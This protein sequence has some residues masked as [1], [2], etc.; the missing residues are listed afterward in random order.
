MER[1]LLAGMFKDPCLLHGQRYLKN[2]LI[3][4]AICDLESPLPWNT[5]AVLLEV[6]GERGVF[7][8]ASYTWGKCYF[9]YWETTEATVSWRRLLVNSETSDMEIQS[10]GGCKKSNQVCE[11]RRQNSISSIQGGEGKA[12]RQETHGDGVRWGRFPSHLPHSSCKHTGQEMDQYLN[13]E[14]NKPGL[15]SGLRMP[16]AHHWIKHLFRFFI[17]INTVG[18]LKP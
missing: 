11:R 9:W 2:T 15:S 14:R 18:Q 6:I 17:N 4:P 5:G 1:Q 12:F 8:G 3:F 10:Q 7:Q 13:R 16:N